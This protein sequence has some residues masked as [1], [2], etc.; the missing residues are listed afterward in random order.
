MNNQAGETVITPK[1]F[2]FDRTIEPQ[3][4]GGKESKVRTA[5]LRRHDG[6]E[7][8]VIYKRGR[9]YTEDDQ[10]KEFI[11]RDEAE[12]YA[13]EKKRQY[14]NFV[15]CFG[16]EF[17]GETHLTVGE[18]ESSNIPEVHTI[19]EPLDGTIEDITGTN[20]VDVPNEEY[21]ERFAKALLRIKS[22]NSINDLDDNDPFERAVKEGITKNHE[23]LKRFYK[24]YQHSVM[25]GFIPDLQGFHPTGD[26]EDD[27]NLL[28]LGLL[29]NSNVGVK[30]TK[31][32]EVQIK[33][34]DFGYPEFNVLTLESRQRLQNLIDE[35]RENPIDEQ[36]KRLANWYKLALRQELE[37][38]DLDVP[39]DYKPHGIKTIDGLIRHIESLLFDESTGFN[40][41]NKNGYRDLDVIRR[42]LSLN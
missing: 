26:Y 17:V 31:L 5:R 39:A 36:N 14:D 16:R 19:Q 29:F 21:N 40:W 4:F 10:E 34:F 37:I 6:T 30:R 22:V 24:A 11:S 33:M 28:L 27:D 12:A 7:Q 23:L 41:T 15:L 20:N 2:N 38:T 9:F 35:K 1:G 18:D 25:L 13:L 32:G 42:L 8:D 3:V